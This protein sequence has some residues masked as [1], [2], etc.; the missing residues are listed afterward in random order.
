MGGA[1]GGG[2]SNQEVPDE[3][4]EG[5]FRCLWWCLF[6]TCFLTMVGTFVALNVFGGLVFLILT[7]WS[8]YMVKNN[9]AEMSQYCMF[10][11]GLMC[12]MQAIF[13]LITLCM[14]V[15]GRRTEST[16]GGPSQGGG[17]H[18][19]GG[20]PGAYGT[21][22]RTD[23]YTTT[24]VTKPFFDEASGWHYNLQSAMMI[25]GLVVML[26]GA[27]LAKYTYGSYPN[28]LFE[29][30]AESQQESQQLGGGGGAY[31]RQG[32]GGGYGGGGGGGYHNY[33]TGGN[34]APAG[35]NQTGNQPRSQQPAMFGGS[36]QTLGSR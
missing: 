35:G 2:L 3:L 31:N 14:S 30:P 16:V 6:T 10:S 15:G 27:L 7:I 19:P 5:K 11:F 26:L 12:A 1:M 32:G 8:Y 22:T 13:E 9:C 34:R 21:H 20:A 18:G 36:G 4:K 24:I 28:G 29:E 25:V 33:Q 23:S 17:M